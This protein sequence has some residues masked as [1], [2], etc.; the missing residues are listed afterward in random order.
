MHGAPSSSDHAYTA[1]CDATR[2]RGGATGASCPAPA[3]G[4]LALALPPG[5]GACPYTPGPRAARD[6]WWARALAGLLAACT[7]GGVV[8]AA[9]ADT[10]CASS[11]GPHRGA[12]P[13]PLGGAA[14]HGA[15]QC[16]QAPHVPSRPVCPHRL[17]PLPFQTLANTGCS[18]PPPSSTRRPPAPGRASPLRARSPPAWAVAA[19]CCRTAAARRPCQRP[20]PR[21]ARA[22]SCCGCCCPSACRWVSCGLGWCTAAWSDACYLE[23]GGKR[24][25][26]ARSV[27]HKSP[28][29][30]SI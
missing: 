22:R 18:R 2:A 29:A 8:A 5:A 24:T 21:S 3:P 16:A 28:R 11:R 7:L 26:C 13:R 12:R 9:R 1:A 10:R 27:G 23:L 17:V 30:A 20:R 15:A 25:A 19:R 14:Q 4:A 6:V